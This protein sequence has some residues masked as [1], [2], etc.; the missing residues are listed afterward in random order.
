MGELLVVEG[1]LTHPY[2]LGIDL[3]GKR[4]IYIKSMMSYPGLEGQLLAVQGVKLGKKG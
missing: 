1:A 4:L 3:K 2:Q